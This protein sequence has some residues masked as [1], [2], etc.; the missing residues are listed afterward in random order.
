MT[1][2]KRTKLKSSCNCGKE[3]L[4]LQVDFSFEKKHLNQFLSSNFREIKSYTN[5]GILYIEDDNL[6][7]IGP[8]GSNRLQIKCKNSNC[9]LSLNIIENILKNME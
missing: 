5:L 1:N 7:A 4:L 3:Q 8:F 6:V 2:V 9:N